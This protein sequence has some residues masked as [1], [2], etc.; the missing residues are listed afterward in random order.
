MVGKL[1][2]TIH[3]N[4]KCPRGSCE[5]SLKG[6]HVPSG[7]GLV[8]GEKCNWKLDEETLAVEWKKVYR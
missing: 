2:K 6:P 5:Q 4:L 1:E 3:K 8:E 7:E